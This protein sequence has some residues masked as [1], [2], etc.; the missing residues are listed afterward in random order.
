MRPLLSSFVVLLAI[1]APAT[2]RAAELASIIG[3][4]GSARDVQVVGALAYVADGAGGLRL[5]DLTD[6]A[7]PAPLGSVPP[8]A[9]GTARAVEVAGT[10]AYV[11]NGDPGVQIVDVGDP[12]E[13]IEIG[14]FDPAGSTSITRAQGDIVYAA[15]ATGVSVWNVADPLLPVPLG[16]LPG[17]AFGSLRI[18]NGH[19]VATTDAA[20][21]RFRVISVANPATP[22]EIASLP[23]VSGDIAVDGDTVWVS[24]DDAFPSGLVGID[25]SNPALPTV[26]ARAVAVDELGQ[27]AGP[28][29]VRGRTLFAGSLLMASL[30]DIGSPQPHR[31]GA[32]DLPFSAEDVE[33]SDNQAYVTTQN[34]GATD[35]GGLSIVE[36]Q[37]PAAPTVAVNVPLGRSFGL[38]VVK[39]GTVRTAYVA[40][41]E[42]L[43]LIDVSIPQSPGILSS[44][45]LNGRVLDVDVE[46]TI[47]AALVTR[48]AAGCELVTVDVANPATPV[49]LDRMSFGGSPGTVVVT[50]TTAWVACAFADTVHVVDL[51][52]P[53]DLNE[54]DTIVSGGDPRIARDGDFLYIQTSGE[55]SIYNV[56]NPADSVF[57]GSTPFPSGA[58]PI[59][60]DAQNRRLFAPPLRVFSYRNPAA[61]RLQNERFVEDALAVRS[62]RLV[63]RRLYV[64]M[65]RAGFTGRLAIY[66]V[67]EPGRS[68]IAT[69]YGTG[70]VGL[71]T[72]IG[73]NFDTGLVVSA[74]GAAG[75]QVW[76][77]SADVAAH[78]CIDGIDNDGDGDVDGED[79]GCLDA[80]DDSEISACIDGI[81]NDGDGLVDRP[82]D[83]GCATTLA[84]RENP[85]CQDGVDNDGDGAVDWPADDKCMSATDNDELINTP[86]C[87]LLGIEPALV[88][89]AAAVAKRRRSLRAAAR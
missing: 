80:Y 56:A 67:E 19:L 78:P 59:R 44:P 66:D 5:F 30:D 55:V 35:A 43:T 27:I 16:A 26:F 88:L 18:A 38:D 89:A 28:P 7:N 65:W 48:L 3:T 52:D 75:L 14:S 72:A 6:P 76:D 62:V 42:S 50:G 64:P 40:A 86:T 53:A 20:S 32:V 24:S 51:S 23:D 9:G 33:I 82:A 29:A 58:A 81:D 84:V 77:A 2:P 11:A 10:R 60:I 25:L 61:P 79:F 4:N 13:P 39:T 57:I 37:N 34:P 85:Q 69:L 49:V 45:D 17:P 63:G 70:L 47:A 36:V 8:L 54:I 21:P 12:G 31:L 22:V 46:G 15:S 83:P 74:L 71:P 73:V 41:E 68:E 87:G 1:A